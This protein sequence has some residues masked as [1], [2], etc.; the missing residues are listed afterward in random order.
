MATYQFR[1]IKDTLI[2]RQVSSNLSDDFDAVAEA[3]AFARDGEIEVWEHDRFVFR[4]QK[5]VEGPSPS[6]IPNNSTAP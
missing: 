6:E 5:R 3:E 1:F 2:Q 4:V